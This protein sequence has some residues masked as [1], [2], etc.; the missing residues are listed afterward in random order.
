MKILLAEDDTKIADYIVAGLAE[1]GHSVD[2]VADGRD[3]LSYCL[4]NDCDMAIL[5]RMLPGMGPL[6][7]QGTQGVKES[8]AGAFPNRLGASRRP[9]RRSGGR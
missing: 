7:A 8:C 9:R 4:Y 2:H 6:G 1:H 5:D 3:A